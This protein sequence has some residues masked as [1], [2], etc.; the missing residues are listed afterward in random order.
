MALG[1]GRKGKGQETPAPSTGPAPQ[2]T[3]ALCNLPGLHRTPA[4]PACALTPSLPTCTAKPRGR[5]CFLQEVLQAPRSQ[6]QDGPALW[7]TTLVRPSPRTQN[8]ED[9]GGPLALAQPWGEWAAG[10]RD[11]RQVQPR[12]AGLGLSARRLPLSTEPLHGRAQP[13]R[14][15]ASPAPR[16]LTP[17][18]LPHGPGCGGPPAPRALP[19][20]R[21][22]A[23]GRPLAFESGRRPEWPFQRPAGAGAVP[24]GPALAPLPPLSH[25]ARPPA[26][27]HGRRPSPAWERR[28][29]GARPAGGRLA[30]SSGR[31]GGRA[32]GRAC[33][34]WEVT[35]PR[36][37]GMRRPGCLLRGQ[38][39]PFPRAWEQ[40]ASSGPDSI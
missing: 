23:G 13:R 8:T 9:R 34:A 40:V 4:P 26:G 33:A 14:P 15:P 11:T 35:G 32:W 29:P 39:T 5:R 10:P 38:A 20:G 22:R 2:L 16:R 19:A 12:A 17:R 36:G 25:A 18:P 21:A 31:E 6:S 3:P 28:A 37:R 1:G 24:G 7:K 27:S 30:G